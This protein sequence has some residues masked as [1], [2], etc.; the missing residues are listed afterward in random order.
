MLS[1]GVIA[2]LLAACGGNAQPAAQQPT[3]AAQPTDSPTKAPEAT[4]AP[5]PTKAPA[6]EIKLVKATFAKKLGE[7]QEPVEEAKGNA[8]FPDETIYL[9][10]QFDGRPKK[11]EVE[12]TFYSK[13][14]KITS[15]KVDLASINSG[16]I[17][18]VGESTYVGFNLK[19]QDSWP[20]SEQYS[21]EVTVDGKPLDTYSYSVVPP[22]DAGPTNVTTVVLAAGADDKYAPIGEATEFTPDQEVFLV[23]R[24][25]FGMGTWLQAD[26]Y[27]D[28]K[29]QTDATRTLGPVT[30]NITD[31]G[32]SFSYKPKGSW[33]TGKQEVA[34]IVNDKEVGRYSFTIT[35][36]P[37]AQPIAPAQAGSGDALTIGDLQSY[38]YKNDLFTIEI[39]ADWKLTD[40]SNAN[41][42]SVA[43]G[44]PGDNAGIV[45]A[46]AQTTGTLSADDL[47]TRGEKFVK[48][49]FG[50]EDGFEVSKP[51]TQKDG[52]VLLPFTVSPT[53]N[54]SAVELY[55]LTYVEQRGDKFST[56]TVLYPK[57]QEQELWDSHFKQ[58]VNSYKLD[59]TVTMP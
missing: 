51:E 6:T 22:A 38:S 54:G 40:S 36:T 58:I 3:I 31:T 2:A 52:S 28:G 56:L 13:A 25:D 44:A 26:W 42:V 9:S 30:D 59:E 4:K 10:L 16:V 12:A 7:N 14:D 1:I 33:P 45:I 46:I 11:G 19:P 29:I 37:A 5:E 35:D 8:F 48:D 50:S 24:G 43:W 34:L 47:S 32:F 39:P 55:G 21:V 15:A 53:I 20:I 27:I 23:G 57:A 41:A 17:L 18:S 49:V